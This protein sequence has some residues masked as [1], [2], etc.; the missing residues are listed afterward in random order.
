[1]LKVWLGNVASSK[2]LRCL[3]SI[4]NLCREIGNVRKF[5]LWYKRMWERKWNWISIVKQPAD[6]HLDLSQK[7][8]IPYHFLMYDYKNIWLGIFQDPRNIFLS[9]PVLLLFSWN[10]QQDDFLL[11]M[12]GGGR[13]YRQHW[14]CKENIFWKPWPRLIDKDMCRN[15]ILQCPSVCTHDTPKGC[16]LWH[17]ANQPLETAIH[18]KG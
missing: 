2:Y 3:I 10:Y 12:G 8:P 16:L 15:C 4:T 6:M 13:E 9:S 14:P 11:I 18:K 17:T 1:M 7:H 5:Q